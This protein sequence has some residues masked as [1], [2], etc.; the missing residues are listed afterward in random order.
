MQD[1]TD[2][3]LQGCRGFIQPVFGGKLAIK[4]SHE[5]G[6]SLGF[7][8]GGIMNHQVPS[9]RV[10]GRWVWVGWSEELVKRSMRVVGVEVM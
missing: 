2:Y 1:Y 4:S 9:P 3:R 7:T 8:Q 5:W 10:G 6:E